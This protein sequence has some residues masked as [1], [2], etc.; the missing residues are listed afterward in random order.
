MFVRRPIF[1]G[2]SDLDQLEKIFWLCGTPTPETWPD[3]DNLPG[4]DGVKTFKH[5]AKGLRDF[6]GRYDRQVF[7][8]LTV[9]GRIF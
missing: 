4:L 9:F 3:F 8:P 2:T 1:Q 6:L 7:S 5:R